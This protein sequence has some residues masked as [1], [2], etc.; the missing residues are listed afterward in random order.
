MTRTF[1][2][3]CAPLLALALLGGCRDEQAEGP[4]K[5]GIYATTSNG[6]AHRAVFNKDGTYV[7]MQ[8]NVPKP[9]AQGKWS[10]RDGKLCLHE[11][12]AAEPLCAEEKAV[13]TD[14]SF[15]I[16]ANGVTQDFKMV[17]Q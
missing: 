12:G 10:R 7:D 14:G 11:D 16:T 15:S 13:G 3:I 8:D 4:M 5:P 6:I 2:P 17:A 1:L 9:V